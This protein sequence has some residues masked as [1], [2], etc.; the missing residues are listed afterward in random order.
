MD[1]YGAIDFVNEKVVLFMPKLDNFYKIWM[2][3]LSKEEFKA[4]Y[5]TVDEIYYTDE[6]EQYFKDNQPDTV[7]LNKGVNSDSGLNTMIAEEEKYKGVCP[8]AKTDTEFMH[9]IL[10]E[11]RT[12]KNDEEIE[13][14]TWASKI[15]CEA[16]CS[17]MRN[18]K[19]G[20]R[21]S[22]LE[23]FFVFDC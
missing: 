16:H 17:V 13:V 3:T 20:L 14:M 5:T 9:D 15:T 18:C 1:A 6:I 10:S 12:I 8:N 7:F 22:Q 21:E 11:S 19:P 4:K 2:T 23:S